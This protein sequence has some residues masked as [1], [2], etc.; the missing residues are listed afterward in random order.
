MVVEL[1]TFYG[2]S[3]LVPH[4]QTPPLIRNV[5]VRDITATGANKAIDIIGLPEKPIEDVTFDNVDIT[6]EH[7][8]RCVDAQNLRFDGMHIAAQEPPPFSLENVKH[9][10]LTKSCGGALDNCV[11]MVGS[12]QGVTF[13][14]AGA[15][16]SAAPP[17]APAHQM[18]KK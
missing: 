3:T 16:A 5:H 8:V 17:P 6:S 2:S 1:T 12:N 4:T 14:G 18:S 10:S 7:G 11:Q 13:D 15:G 9:V